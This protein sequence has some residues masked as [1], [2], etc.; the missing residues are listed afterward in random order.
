MTSIPNPQPSR[1]PETT[2]VALSLCFTLRCR[3]GVCTVKSVS[4][5]QRNTQ[6][7]PRHSV[8]AT[9]HTPSSSLGPS[10]LSPPSHSAPC[11][12]S[13]SSQ[14]Y[15][16]AHYTP[17]LFCHTQLLVLSSHTAAPWRQHRQHT[18]CTRCAR[19]T[20]TYLLICICLPSNSSPLPSAASRGDTRRRTAAQRMPST[21]IALRCSPV[22]LL[23]HTS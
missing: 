8:H 3:R 12:C 17:H 11:A 18:T 1:P 4:G 7:H 16:Y 22:C 5:I 9:V 21:T 13:D 2:S 15:H 10:L 19:H 23:I 20:T 14:H 6:P